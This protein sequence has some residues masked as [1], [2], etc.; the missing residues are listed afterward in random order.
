MSVVC[1]NS[2]SCLMLN[3]LR[4]EL[5]SYQICAENNMQQISKINMK[6]EQTV[7]ELSTIVNIFEYINLVTDYKNLFAIIN[8]MLIGVLGATSSTIFTHDGDKF[9]VET[10]S[11]PRQALMNIKHTSNKLDQF[12]DRLC[13][14]FILSSHEL[15]DEFSQARAIKSAMVVPLNSKNKLIGIIYL[16]HIKDGYFTTENARYM[17]TLA[18]AIRLSLENAKLYAKLEEMA[19]MDGLTGLYNRMFF[20][21]EMRNC[22]DNYKKFRL[23]FVL[24][25][26]DIDHF[27]SVNDT[28]GHLTGDI[29]LK[30]ISDLIKLGV[31]KDDIVCRYGGEEFAI[32]FRSTSDMSSIRNRLEDLRIRISAHSINC[33]QETVSVTCSFG[34][35]CCTMF[36]LYIQA[37]DIIKRADD[38]LYEAKKSGRNK[39]VIDN[40]EEMRGIYSFEQGSND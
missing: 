6:Y 17:N 19:L 38:A 14:T 24:A 36:D 10:S 5:D 18:V 40:N 1:Q 29:L 15:T 22:M 12:R 16:E 30:E 13:E 35:V 39:V 32:I 9:T 2:Q 7:S 23:P 8:D 34:A 28:F 21:K 25:I 20:N 4:N 31:R 27:K 11:I 26:L 33:G 3:S 37:E